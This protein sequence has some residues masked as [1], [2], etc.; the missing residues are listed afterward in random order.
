MFRSMLMIV[1][2]I[3]VLLILIHFLAGC[4]AVIE[5]EP[6]HHRHDND[7]RVVIVGDAAMAEMEMG[8]IS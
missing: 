5:S 4:S 8:C 2:V 3:I 6:V 7:T 1:F